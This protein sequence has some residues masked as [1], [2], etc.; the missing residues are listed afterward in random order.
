V[1]KGGVA[2]SF[3]QKVGVFVQLSFNLLGHELV[4]L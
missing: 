2:L 4:L 1:V 3:D